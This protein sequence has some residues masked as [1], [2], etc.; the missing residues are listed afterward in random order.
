MM[1]LVLGLTLAG[2]AGGTGGTPAMVFR[3]S[4]SVLAD[5]GA[6]P[7][8]LASLPD[9]TGIAANTTA[10]TTGGGTITWTGTGFTYTPGGDDTTL[11]E[12]QLVS[13]MATF[14]NDVKI[15]V[16]VAGVVVVAALLRAST[17]LL[18]AASGQLL[19]I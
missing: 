4:N 14:S 5:A 12:G 3:A 16:Q 7:L 10:A 9:M 6:T 13:R 17:G 15:V 2:E 8:T 18:R 19:R 11:V 1:D